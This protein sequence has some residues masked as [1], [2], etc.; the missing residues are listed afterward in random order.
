MCGAGVS[1][2]PGQKNWNCATPRAGFI[3][4]FVQIKSEEYVATCTAQKFSYLLHEIS[5]K[6]H[7]RLDAPHRNV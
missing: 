3:S 5:T 4:G 2:R 6:S 1:I 7:K